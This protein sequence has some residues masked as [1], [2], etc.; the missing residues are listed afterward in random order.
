[1]ANSEGIPFVS[2][3][4]RKIEYLFCKTAEAY[5]QDIDVIQFCVENINR[6]ESEKSYIVSQFI[7][8]VFQ[9]VSSYGLNSEDDKESDKYYPDTVN[10]IPENF[11]LNGIVSKSVHAPGD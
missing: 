11:N 7:K 10:F 5:G 8:I 2:Y 6:Y 4:V 1:M 3:P 9:W